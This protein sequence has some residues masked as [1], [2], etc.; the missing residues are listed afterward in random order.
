MRY[1]SKVVVLRTTIK[2]TTGS[3]FRYL[4]ARHRRVTRLYSLDG[5]NA[6]TRDV[7]IVINCFP[8]APGKIVEI[9]HVIL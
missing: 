5:R 1:Q 3:S 7:I 4:S 6:H 8:K 9:E 2:A